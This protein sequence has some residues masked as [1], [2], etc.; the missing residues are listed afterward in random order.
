[1]VLIIYNCQHSSFFVAVYYSN[2]IA[3][4]ITTL[5]SGILLLHRLNK[6]KIPL[7]V[8]GLLSPLEGFLLFTFICGISR[9]LCSIIFLSN[10]E[11]RNYILRQTIE[12]W[13]WINIQLS[14]ATY[15][16]GV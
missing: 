9:M 16:A 15:L 12:D 1:M 3:S 2:L 4:V 11:P 6:R 8:E 10:I 7:F 13:T 5:F 14:V